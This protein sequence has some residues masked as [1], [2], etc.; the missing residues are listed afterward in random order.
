MVLN[1]YPKRVPDPRK[2]R[3]FIK[4]EMAVKTLDQAWHDYHQGHF[5][6]VFRCLRLLL[7]FWPA[8]LFNHNVII[9]LMT[10]VLG[11]EAAAYLRKI[12]RDFIKS[13]QSV[14]GKRL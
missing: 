6:E 1:K 8:F 2:M 4:K 9:L 10:L 12:R 13:L 14:M 5:R 7:R 3:R 11:P